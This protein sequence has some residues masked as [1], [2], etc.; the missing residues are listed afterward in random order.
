[1]NKTNLIARA[2]GFTLV[3]LLIAI[4]IFS[5][6]LLA[7]A[8]M[9]ITSIRGNSKANIVTSATS[10]AEGVMEEILAWDSD[11]PIFDTDNLAGTA[12]N[13]S[14]TATPQY[15]IFV[16]GGGTFSAT[17]KID[18]DFSSNISRIEVEVQEQGGVLSRNIILVGFKRRV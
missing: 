7:I 11:N 8:A 10:V 13:F 1:M 14:D 4:T 17:Y 12:W 3:E 9:Q 16:P 18:A 5:I 2:E 6:G 15:S